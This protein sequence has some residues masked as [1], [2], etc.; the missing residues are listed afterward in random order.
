MEN[1]T[2]NSRPDP[3]EMYNESASDLGPLKH[4]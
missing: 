2:S 3:H 1:E 4:S